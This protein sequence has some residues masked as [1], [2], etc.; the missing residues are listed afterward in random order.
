MGVRLGG[1]FRCRAASG[2]PVLLAAGFRLLPALPGLDVPDPEPPDLELFGL[3][4]PDPEPFGL[5]RGLEA[6]GLCLLLCSSRSIVSTL[7]G[8]PSRALSF[9]YLYIRPKC[10][11][12]S[13]EI[14]IAP[15]NVS[16]TAKAAFS[17]GL[18]GSHRHSGSAPQI[19]GL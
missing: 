19:R 3:E 4:L 10:G 14:L 11:Q 7:H 5:G 12:L 8:G 1:C 17:L 18:E 16:D 13:G 15:Q 6:G 2:L 9:V